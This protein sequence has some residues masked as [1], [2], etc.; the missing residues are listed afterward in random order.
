LAL[1]FL[2]PLGNHESIDR[3]I[4]LPG[5]GAAMIKVGAAAG[6]VAAGMER[7]RDRKTKRGLKVAGIYDSVPRHLLSRLLKNAHLLRCATNLIARRIFII[8]LALRFLR[9]LHLSI[10]ERPALSG[11]FSTPC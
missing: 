11:C 1:L 9:A 10:F 5:A 4:R 7:Q 3:K 8:R 6:N 2:P